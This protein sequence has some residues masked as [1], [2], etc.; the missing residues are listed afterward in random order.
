MSLGLLKSIAG[1][2]SDALPAAVRPAPV[3]VPA[4]AAEPP[5]DAGYDDLLGRWLGFSELQNHCL[6]ALATEVRRTSDLVESS[7]LEISSR[8]RDLATSAQEQTKRVEDIIAV[9]NSVTI[10][11]EAIPL[12]RVV[13]TMQQI[14]VEMVNNIV[15]LSKQAMTMV[16]VLDDVV[17]DVGEVEK[18]IADIDTINR[19]TNFL[20]LNATI[21]ASRAGEAGR[22]FAVVANEVR[23]L[24]KA[25]GD[26]AGRMRDK[27]GAVVVGVR[28][29]HEILRDIANTDLSPQMLAKDR[30]DM[31]MMSLVAQSQHFQSVLQDAARVST[32]ISAHISQVITRMQ[33][34][35]LAK[36]R[37]DHVIDG[38]TVMSNGLGELGARTRLA[39]PAGTGMDFPQEW[40]DQLL[41]GMT[42]SELRQRFV[43]RMLLAG[44]ALDAHGALDHETGF[45]EAD[46]ADPGLSDGTDD[47]N[48]ELF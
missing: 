3:P 48:V 39:L 21:E 14:L 24:S 1:S 30:I 34:Q 26:L 17:R 46:G 42:L 9:A 7:T 11:G 47:D 38:M 32:E 33:F 29:G 45:P 12:D 19:Q 4:P 41:S 5:A 8:F 31:T 18:S 25:T 22:T 37:L 15:N 23:H 35:D 43:R 36:Q 16:Y 27:V 40:V 13:A 6:D 20:A 44:S 28:R 2:R 10:D